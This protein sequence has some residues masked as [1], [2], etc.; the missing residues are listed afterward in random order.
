MAHPS[1]VS[2]HSQVAVLYALLLLILP[3]S[4]AEKSAIFVGGDKQLFIDDKFIESSEGVTL[5]MNPPY[6]T[7]EILLTTDQPWEQGA[8]I[9]SYNSILKEE[10]PDGPRIRLWY[11]LIEGKGVP[12]N[13]FRAVAYAESEDGVHFRKPIL[14][15]VELKGSKENNLVFPADLSKMTV[16]GG[17]VFR[18]ENPSCPPGE[19]YKSWSKLYQTPG[20]YRGANRFWYSGDGL[21]WHLYD[22]MPTGLR[23]ADTQPTWFWDQ[24][25]KRYRGY[26][27]EKPDLASGKR[28]RMGGYN[29]SDDM[30]HW[31]SFMIVIRADE[32][33]LGRPE[34]L[35][36]YAES[37]E[38]IEGFTRIP[39]KVMDFYGPGVFQYGEA[40]GIYFAMI[41]AFYHWRM[42][43]G[44][45]WP[46]TADVQL[47]VSRDG[48]Q[49]RRLGGRK[50][51]LRL[52]PA[53]SFYSKWVW[54]MPQP[55]RMGDELWIYYS[56]NNDDH[57]GRVD[58][59]AGQRMTGVTRAILRLDGFVSADAAYTGGTLTTPPIIFE[60]KS[61][62]LN[63]DTSA[64]GVAQIEI[65]EASGKPV[66][67]YT[68]A[69]ADEL[70][71]NSVRM[72]VSWQGRTDL[73]VLAGRPLKLHFKLRD[74]KLYAY[75]FVGS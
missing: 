58:P 7:G 19:R 26:S 39:A 14:K 28:T 27:R 25:I 52:G 60:G 18:D 62:E 73:S 44:K 2:Q 4:A 65:Q 47:A 64:G 46:D 57:S 54:F 66:P 63:L 72:S 8:Y 31:D 29:E 75:Q 69:E 22:T 11:D 50:P 20:T 36:R 12:G 56:G 49:F 10:G 48:R 6:Q 71:G 55:V 53:G 23:A 51:F 68:L 42:D 9:G 37:G 5:V 40:P 70:N 41:S 34:G 43:E 24:L 16:G 1:G 45:S 74:C 30:L 61:L 59:K 32:T 3:A 17:S 21:H 15:L 38:A 33:D 67:G 13:G 35:T